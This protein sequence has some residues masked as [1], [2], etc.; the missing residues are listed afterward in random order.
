MKELE[1]DRKL[2][3]LLAQ[4]S[5]GAVACGP[6]L[7]TKGGAGML[8]LEVPA[9]ELT[10]AALD[11]LITSDSP[12]LHGYQAGTT[13]RNS[14]VPELSVELEGG[15]KAAIKP[16]G[17]DWQVMDEA[18]PEKPVGADV[19]RWNASYTDHFVPAVCG[20]PGERKHCLLRF[21]L[22]SLAGARVVSAVVSIAAAPVGKAEGKATVFPI[23]GPDKQWHCSKAAWKTRDGEFGWTGGKVDA[24][25]RKQLLEEF[26]KSQPPE[27]AAARAKELLAGL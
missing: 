16:H 14:K 15:T 18:Q 19:W 5:E 4:T 6:A 20:K 12:S 2:D 11:L 25:K 17:W 23:R 21:P 7:S 3:V 22:Q 1:A 27:K 9:A 10:G 13:A 8:V 24:A 26:L